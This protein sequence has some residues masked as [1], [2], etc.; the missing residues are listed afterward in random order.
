MGLASSTL[1]RAVTQSSVR[2]TQTALRVGDILPAAPKVA[3]RVGPPE[4][5]ALRKTATAPELTLRSAAANSRSPP[6]RVCSQSVSASGVS[7]AF[8]GSILRIKRLQQAVPLTEL[9]PQRFAGL[10]FRADDNS[11]IPSAFALADP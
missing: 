8:S 3:P 10:Q 4:D 1:S 11:T 7:V 9:G 5:L 6:K 2:K